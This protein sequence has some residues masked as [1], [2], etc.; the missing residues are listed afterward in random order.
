MRE[1]LKKGGKNL[2]TRD[3]C[4]KTQGK[5]KKVKERIV[6]FLLVGGGGG[7]GGRGGGVFMR[8]HSMVLVGHRNVNFIE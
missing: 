6:Q 5:K 3:N 2:K 1:N 4:L 7:G 8:R